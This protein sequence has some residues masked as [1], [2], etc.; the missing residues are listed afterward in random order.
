VL[1]ASALFDQ[2]VAPF[3]EQVRAGKPTFSL[4]EH[5]SWSGLFSLAVSERFP[6]GTL[7]ALEPNRSLW[8]HH[9]SLARMQ[10][11]ANVVF[12]NNPL[13]YEVAEALA[14]SNEFL[15]G[16][17]LLSLHTARP[18]DHGSSI[19]VERLQQ[20]D[21]YIGHLLSLARYTLMLLP[22]PD[23]RAVCRDNRL[24][25]WTYASVT[26]GKAAL[27]SA[28]RLEAAGRAFGLRLSVR[29]VTR[30]VALDGCEYEVWRVTLLHMDRL[31]R[32]HYCLGGCKT[33]TR[34]TYRMIYDAADPENP[35]A[36]TASLV[37]GRMNMTNTQTGRHI[38]FETGS[39]NMHTLLSLQG[40]PVGAA[41]DAA[42]AARQVLI[43][44]FLSL[45]VFQDP[46]P[47][48]VVWRAGEL[49]PIDVGDGL[50]MEQRPVQDGKSPWDVFA[51]KYIGS[52]S[53]CYRMSLKT[54]C[55]FTAPFT[56]PEGHG[57]ERYATCM[58]S[59]FTGLCPTERP[60]PC[61]DGCNKSYQMCRHLA[62][63]KVVP[64]WFAATFS[65]VT[66]HRHRYSQFL[67][68]PSDGPAPG[69]ASPA[70]L[71][72]S[73]GD[74][75][76]GLRFGW[77]VYVDAAAEADHAGSGLDESGDHPEDGGLAASG[78]AH[79]EGEPA[80]R[81]LERHAVHRDG[82]SEGLAEFLERDGNHCVRKIPVGIRGT[83]N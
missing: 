67:S 58:Q 82:G 77:Q 38:P 65:H 20:I 8:A 39:M 18:F 70:V 5:G 34:R 53:E 27:A 24:A 32:H 4:L 68:R 22:A 55:G 56:A 74:G 64:G 19:S 11:R 60:F 76:E 75:Y 13:T 41:V 6:R 35:T 46:A 9:A 10:R 47:W 54:L 71:G 44:M 81:R 49:F 29:R 14:H 57:D 23:Q 25:Q 80:G 3:L 17:L 28:M 15:D 26:P 52:V 12:A 72:M 16:Q 51:Q 62:P 59:H 66:A 83:R 2:A 7:V 31:N 45:P 30:G 63:A 61:L 1:D 42:E 36:R 78:W 21:K 69:E 33:H 43:L 40:E 48:N 37:S 50:T 79:Q 73:G